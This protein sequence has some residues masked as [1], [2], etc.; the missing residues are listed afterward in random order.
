MAILLEGHAG[1]KIDTQTHI[2]TMMRCILLSDEICSSVIT[3]SSL[4][5]DI[6]QIEMSSPLLYNE[7]DKLTFMHWLRY[8]IGFFSIS[9]VLSTHT[10]QTRGESMS[11]LSEKISYILA[12]A[13]VE[14]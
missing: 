13:N 5:W 4:E 3:V 14:T 10:N 6:F 12:N 9:A 2:D 11:T 7:R 8:H 1:Q